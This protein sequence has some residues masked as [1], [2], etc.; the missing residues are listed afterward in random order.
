MIQ[1]ATDIEEFLPPLK[2]ILFDRPEEERSE[3]LKIKA[4][5]MITAGP[6]FKGFIASALA[7]GEL[8]KLIEKETK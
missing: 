7:F 2:G 8:C 1:N 3:I 5:I 6:G 4:A